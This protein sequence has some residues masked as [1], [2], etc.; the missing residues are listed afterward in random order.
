MRTIYKLSKRGQWSNDF[1]SSDKV[2]FII[3]VLSVLML[4]PFRCIFSF[5]YFFI[6]KGFFCIFVCTCTCIYL[7]AFCP[8]MNTNAIHNMVS[9]A[10]LGLDFSSSPRWSKIFS[11]HVSTCV[12]HIFYIIPGFCGQF[13][14]LIVVV[15]AACHCCGSHTSLVADH[16]LSSPSPVAHRQPQ[17]VACLQRQLVAHCRPLSPAAVCC[18][19]VPAVARS[20][21]TPI[22][23]WP[24][25]CVGAR[26]VSGRNRSRSGC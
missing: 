19:P 25:A 11:M 26:F 15:A 7:F 10:N 17:L 9:R 23:T 22:R 14:Q 3:A 16:R 13:F 5:L 6:C 1:L 24:L 8:Q 21:W 12:H 18:S 4:S 20:C 2:S